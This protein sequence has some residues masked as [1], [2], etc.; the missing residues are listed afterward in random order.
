VHE[1]V[2][3]LLTART[4]ANDLCWKEVMVKVKLPSA[5]WDTVLYLLHALEGQGYLLGPLRK[6]IEDQVY[7]QEN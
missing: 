6:E 2:R 5:D 7:G 3:F 4:Q 1:E